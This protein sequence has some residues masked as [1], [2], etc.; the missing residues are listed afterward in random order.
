MD[1]STM[2]IL[3]AMGQHLRFVAPRKER[4][5]CML[6]IHEDLCFNMDGARAPF[7][8]DSFDCFLTQRSTPLIV[9]LLK[10]DSEINELSM[11]V[12][13]SFYFLREGFM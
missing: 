13:C 8:I 2:A 11:Q 12:L 5:H 4:K 10:I 6:L 9:S 1:A 7:E 3:E